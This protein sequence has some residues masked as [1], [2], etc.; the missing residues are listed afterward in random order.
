MPKQNVSPAR[1][2]ELRRIRQAN[3]AKTQEAKR[4]AKTNIHATIVTAPPVGEIVGQVRALVVGTREAQRMGGWGKTKLFE[5][6]RSGELQSFI[7]GSVRRI[8]TASIHAR[9]QRKL[10]EAAGKN[11]TAQ[12]GEPAAP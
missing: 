10:Q 1:A 12:T 4:A 9:I 11:E 7:D 6:I 5:L 2:K 3:A 8:T